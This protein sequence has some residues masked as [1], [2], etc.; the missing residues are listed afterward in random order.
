M[1]PL[2][3][4]PRD[5]QLERA[6]PLLERVMSAPALRAIAEVIEFHTLS[7][8]FDH[9]TGEILFETMGQAGLSDESIADA[10]R[11]ARGDAVAP[12]PVASTALGG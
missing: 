2:D 11:L 8:A 6:F 1:A 10:V 7:Q 3:F 5:E 4:E 9:R 12:G